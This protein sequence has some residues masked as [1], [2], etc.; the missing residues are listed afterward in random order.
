MYYEKKKMNAVKKVRMVLEKKTIYTGIFFNKK[1]SLYILFKICF[2]KVLLNQRV[3]QRKIINKKKTTNAFS[4][5][6]EISTLCF[7]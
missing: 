4:N 6:R 2:F 1:T 3:K 7:S 5:E